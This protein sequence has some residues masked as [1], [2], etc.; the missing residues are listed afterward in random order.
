[1]NYLSSNEIPITELE[2][3]SQASTFPIKDLIIRGVISGVVLAM[4]ASRS[5][6]PISDES[7]IPIMVA[8]MLMLCLE[9]IMGVYTVMAKRTNITGMF[10]NLLWVLIGNAFGLA[11]YG[12]FFVASMMTK[13]AFATTNIS[14]KITNID[15]IQLLA[16]TAHHGLNYIPNLL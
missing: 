7:M 2:S 4:S 9:L 1:M 11:L 10:R 8:I 5:G 3:D 6:V 14:N 13:L 16:Y 12:F 15:N